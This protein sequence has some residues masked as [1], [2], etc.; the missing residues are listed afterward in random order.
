M[1]LVRPIFDYTAAVYHSLLSSEKSSRLERMQKRAVKI[2]CGQT[3]SYSTSI[4]VLGV[5]TL[6]ERRLTLVDNFIDKSIANARFTDRWFPRK[7][8]KTFNT[9]TRN[10]SVTLKEARETN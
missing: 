8:K 7:A 2:I 10:I 3:S 5:D 9:S 6:Q 4:R 1:S